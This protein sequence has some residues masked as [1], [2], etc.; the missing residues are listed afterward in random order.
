[1]LPFADE[2]DADCREAMFE[3]LTVI[4]RFNERIALLKGE[5]ERRGGVWGEDVGGEGVGGLDIDGE[6]VVVAN[7]QASNGTAESGRA[8]NGAP[9]GR[10][11][12]EEFRRRMEAQMGGEDGEEDGVHL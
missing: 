3:N 7:G 10:L 2:G 5:V 4:G 1:M 9:S 12:D 8:T 6:V 11:T